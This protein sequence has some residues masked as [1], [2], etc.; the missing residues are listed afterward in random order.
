MLSAKP[1]VDVKISH[2]NLFLEIKNTGLGPAI[3]KEIIWYSDKKQYANPTHEEF[4]EYLI[5]I[6]LL[7]PGL[8]Y[9]TYDKGLWIK[10][11]ETKRI[12]SFDE[13]EDKENLEKSQ[14]I[15][16]QSI[17]KIRGEIHYSDIYGNK[18]KDRIE[19]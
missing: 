19:S 16:E 11:G 7:V 15:I 5:D 10:A 13:N 4:R 9:A 3:I 6:N 18:F 2:A 12:L 8:L 14:A 17:G 1:H